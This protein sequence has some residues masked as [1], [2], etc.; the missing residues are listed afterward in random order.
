MTNCAPD[1]TRYGVIPINEIDLDMADDLF[2]GPGAVDLS[3]QEAYNEAKAEAERKYANLCEE[4]AIS[5]AESGADREVG[6]DPE[7]WEEKWFDFKGIEHD[8]EIFVERELEQFSDCCQIDEPTIEGEYEG[9]KYFISW[10]GGAPLLW[11]IDGPRG[12]GNRLC[13]P[14][15]PGAVDLSGGYV[16]VDE[17]REED[18]G[19]YSCFCVPRDWLYVEETA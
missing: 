16:L 2:Y 6:F 12:W 19:D 11:V 8:P 14:C 1:G 7:D 18:E 9:V 17:P 5:A 15:V 13:S 10:L 3:Y 4:A